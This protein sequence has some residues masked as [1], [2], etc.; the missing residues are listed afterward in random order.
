MSK[1]PKVLIGT[2]TAQI[3]DYCW[4]EFSERVDQLTY[5][6]SAFYL[7]D[8]S[9]SRK[10]HKKIR[11]QRVDVGFVKRKSKSNIQYICESHNMIRD[12]ALKHNFDYLLHLESDVIPP[13]DVIER[14][15]SHNK[16]VVSAPYHINF[17]DRSQLM[18]V[19]QEPNTIDFL[20]TEMMSIEDGF[21]FLDGTLKKIHNGGLGCTLIH[22]SV[23]EQIPFRYMDGY[24]AHPDTFFAIDLA[25]KKID[26]HVDTSIMCEHRNS[27]WVELD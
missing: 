23:L 18:L 5:K 6:K 27:E 20:E 9:L 19:E 14:L 4:N 15:L 26:F 3:K 22:K 17:G 8:N 21:L 10:Y 7:V 2:P 25:V 12:Y 11:K 13:I 1:K 24:H 16:A